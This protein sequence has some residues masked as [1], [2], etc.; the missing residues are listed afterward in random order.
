MRSIL[1]PLLC[2]AC[3]AS[4]P[5][6]RHA[7]PPTAETVVVTY[8]P[9]AGQEAA[10]QQEIEATWQEM[11][12]LKLTATDDRVFYRGDDDDGHPFFLEIFTWKD[13]DTP[14]HA[15]KEIEE[16]WKKLSD[17]VEARGARPG[18]QFSELHAVAR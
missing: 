16:H 4:A 10:L 18:L 8:L 12:H 1:V 14:D 6:P 5:A 15:P 13:H 11:V 9:K 3:G 2:A 17:L 7:L